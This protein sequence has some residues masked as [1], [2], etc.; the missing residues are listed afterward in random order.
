[1][2]VTGW[3]EKVGTRTGASVAVVERVGE[4]GDVWVNLPGRGVTQASVLASVGAASL[5]QA[6][7]HGGTVA[8]LTEPGEMARP[9]I[10]GV[11]AERLNPVTEATEETEARIDGRRIVLTGQEEVV[12]RCGKASI[13]LT[14][15]GKVLV[16]GAYLLSR[17]SGV[18]RIK[19]GSV[20]IN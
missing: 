7:E 9:V 20:Q 12:L 16:R 15:A 1:M 6:A 3:S 5:R 8:V 13:T 19:G 10:I 2:T 18:N 11:V 14:K 4:S 17:S